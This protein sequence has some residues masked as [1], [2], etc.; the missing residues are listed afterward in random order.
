MK[1]TRSIVVLIALS[2]VAFGIFAA[3]PQ[4]PATAGSGSDKSIEAARL[5]NLGVAYMNQ[6]L[7]EKALKECEGAAALDP[8]QQSAQ[9]N[10]GI[11]LLN[12]QRVDEAKRILEEAIKR[13]PKDAHAWY[14]LALLYKNTSDTKSA[15]DAFRHV[16]EID[17]SDPDA[18]YFLGSVYAQAKQYPQA[19]DAF[20]HA[21]KLNPLHASAEFGLSRACQQSGDTPQARQHLARFQYITQN[22]L[23]SPISLAY[24][25]QGKYS[26]AEESTAALQKVPS[27]I[28]VRFVPVTEE[29]GIVSKAVPGE[30]KDL[31]AFLGPGACLFDYDG[32]GRLDTFL[33]DNGSEGGLA[34]Y[35]NLGNGKFEEVTRKAGLDPTLH[36]IGCTAGD[37]DN[38]GSTDLAVS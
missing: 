23:G 35:H 25:E 28:K 11:A 27:P 33:A 31:A 26:L 4:Q 21:L 16:A 12:L 3:A 7:F 13:D 20:Q 38:D 5:N 9:I 37:Y 32:D 30:A 34:L 18:W 6:Q 24:G 36:G 17:P 8:K 19:I 15:A 14:N 10:R 22:K 2:L 29:A 1:S